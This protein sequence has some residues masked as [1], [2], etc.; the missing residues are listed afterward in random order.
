MHET[1]FSNEIIRVLNDKLK[2][3]DNNSKVVCV[4]VR[5][6][7]LSHV[8]PNTLKSTF[9][10]MVKPSNL[11]DISLNI[12]SPEIELK[13]KSCGRRFLVKSPKLV[14]SHCKNTDFDI[15]EEREFFIESIEIEKKQ[16]VCIWYNVCPLKRFYEQGKLPKRWIEDYC[17]GDNSKCVRKR[18]EEEGRYH[19]D[20][21]LP[22]GAIDKGLR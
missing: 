15:K 8:R 9:L 18:M 22:D 3:L 16:D 1:V 5:L 10:Q 14:C 4:N 21:M 17:R 12:K 20:N 19:P 7:P 6:N 2:G 13:C 11:E